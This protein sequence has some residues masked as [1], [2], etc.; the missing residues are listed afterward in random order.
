[1]VQRKVKMDGSVTVLGRRYL[2][3]DYCRQ[4][5]IGKYVFVDDEGVCK[6]DSPKWGIGTASTVRVFHPGRWD[7]L[8][9][10]SLEE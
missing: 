9:T 10:A 3:P 1:M 4:R 6:E 8:T 5:V 2:I 7:Y